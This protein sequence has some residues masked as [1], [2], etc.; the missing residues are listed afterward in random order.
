M[1]NENVSVPAGKSDTGER[2]AKIVTYAVAI[3]LMLFILMP[4]YVIV[5]TSLREQYDAMLNGFRW[6]PA[7]V[8][9]DGYKAMFAQSSVFDISIPRAFG[10]TLYTVIPMV[11]VGLFTSSM[12]AF[13]FAKLNFTGRN[14][15]FSFM[16]F[17]MMIP[18]TITMVPQS[19]LYAKFHW[20]NTVAP[21]MVPG[22]FGSATTIFF[23][24]QFIRGIPTDLVEAAEIDGLN[25]FMVFVV[26]ILPLCVP[27]LISQGLLW[28]IG[29]YNDYLTPLIYISDIKIFT[30]Q[31]ALAQFRSK[32]ATDIPTLMASSVVSM[33]PLL[34]I[35]VVLQKY[36]ISGIAM[37]GLKA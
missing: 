32:L 27:A 4:F 19:M 25:K 36:F 16:L 15:A 34:V 24:R 17:T 21:L 30:L 20:F 10:V 23:M 14:I 31:L 33:L 5:V 8:V 35:Y 12:A 2:V 1:T 26:V 3:I 6:W 18:G 13:A 37:S 7:E 9:F 29:G 22:M 11:L 28:F